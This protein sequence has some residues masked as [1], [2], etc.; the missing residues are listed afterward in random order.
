M[1]AYGCCWM[2]VDARFRVSHLG[3][4]PRYQRHAQHVELVG[5]P[6]A[7]QGPYRRIAR[8]N[9]APSRGSR[10]AA[11][12]S[13]HVSSQHAPQLGQP[14]HHLPRHLLGHLAAPLAS[15]AAAEAQARSHLLAQQPVEPFHAHT[16][17]IP[18]RRRPHRRPTVEPRKHRRPRQ[19]H[20]L[21]QSLGRRQPRALLLA[22][23]GAQTQAAARR[24]FLHGPAYHAEPSTLLTLNHHS[25][26]LFCLQRY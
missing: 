6:V 24:Q 20:Y 25:L 10:V 11:I 18:H 16:H 7:R 26:L 3:H 1:V 19:F 22:V 2:N 4:H 13:L 14:L 21:G 17:L 15:H 8:Y 23:Q 9:L 5:Q 12:G